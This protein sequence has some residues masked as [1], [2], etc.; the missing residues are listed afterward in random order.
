[1]TMRSL[2]MKERNIEEYNAKRKELMEKSYEFYCEKGLYGPGTG[3]KELAEYC[4]VA[5]ASFYNYFKNKDDLI[6]E[7][8]A[9][10]MEKVEDDFMSLA[11][12][13]PED[14]IRFLNETPEW[15][16]KKHG[17]KY[18]MMYQ[19]YTHPKYF[20]YGKA[21]F[22]GVN[23]RYTEYAKLLESKIGI[24]YMTITPL[25]FIYVRASVHYALFEDKY[26]LETQIEL[27]KKAVMLFMEEERKKRQQEKQKENPT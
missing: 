7:T 1:M 19:V 8:T 5:P 27:L 9:Y 2:L 22:E 13:N 17:K 11:P 3:M 4:S 14:V 16:A 15:T 6:I 12:E 24:P 25:I 18:R 23:K 21:F 20:Q 10:C 26:Y